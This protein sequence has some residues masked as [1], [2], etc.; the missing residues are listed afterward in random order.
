[1]PALLNRRNK[2][3]AAAIIVA[4]S[5]LALTG[6]SGMRLAYNSADFLIERYA[7]DYLGLD[8]AQVQRWAPLLDASLA[9]HREEELPY[10]AA[11]FDTAQNDARKGFDRADVRCLLDQF[12]VIYERHFELASAAAAPLLA[13]LDRGQI[14][15]LDRE[16]REETRDNAERAALPES[17]RVNKRVKRYRKNMRW[18]V[19]DLTERQLEIVRDVVTDLPDSADWYAY[20]D[21]K[22]RELIELLRGGSSAARI[23]RFLID[24]LVDYRDMPASLRRSRDQLQSGVVELFVRLDASFSAEQRRQ[25]IDRL[26]RLRSDFMALQRKPRMAPVSC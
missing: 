7:D 6:C 2:P 18:W 4:L 21:R 24:W 20:R 15:R 9:R 10:L 19:G 25:L 1:M 5:L 8:N 26:S 11:F 12:E 3:L 23:E 13:D 17:A 14:A 16:F 22:R